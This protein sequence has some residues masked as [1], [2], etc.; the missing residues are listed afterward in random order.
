[1]LP[2][3][4]RFFL[5]LSIA[6]PA[7]V[8]AQTSTIQASQTTQPCAACTAPAQKPYA[9]E[10]KTTTVQRLGNGAT[11]TRES[12]EVVAM[13]S[14]GRSVR[15]IT[16]QDMERDAEPHTFTYV[17]GLGGGLPR[18][19]ITGVSANWDS[20]TKQG[21]IINF[22]TG[23]EQHGCWADALGT[24]RARYDNVPSPQMAAYQVQ[25]PDWRKH[26]KNEDLGTT[27]IQGVE[28]MGSRTTITI[29][30]GAVGNDQPLETTSEIWR[31]PT[32]YNLTLR[33]VQND[34]RTGVMTRELV[35][36]TQ[37][38]PDPAI[39]QPP[40]GYEIKTTELHKVPCTQ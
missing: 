32:I 30:A 27:T 22:P 36:L 13:D 39:F 1:M 10:F 24:I 9:A 34:P 31:A 29:P 23:D 8:A 16:Q 4:L 11:I 14:T 38:E 25:V 3:S 20:R 19:S 5:A 33:S 26:P 12:K 40:D 15:S 2:R 21:L 7:L 6:L 18:N 37:G 17:N 35:S 28:A